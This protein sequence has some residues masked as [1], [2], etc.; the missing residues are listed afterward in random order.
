MPKVCATKLR[1]V[2]SEEVSQL[3]SCC[4]S[5]Y[6]V[7]GI[8]GRSDDNGGCDSKHAHSALLCFLFF[9]SIQRSSSLRL[10]RLRYRSVPQDLHHLV[11]P[12]PL[13]F[14]LCSSISY[15]HQNLKLYHQL[16]QTVNKE[17]IFSCGLLPTI[18]FSLF[19][20]ILFFPPGEMI[21]VVKN[22]K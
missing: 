19:C 12:S 17:C 22:L 2:E 10:P 3:Q 8:D 6:W 11:R 1:L 16:D 7:G 21:T 9:P 14:P 20:N 5:D 13:T 18:Y 4:C 15:S